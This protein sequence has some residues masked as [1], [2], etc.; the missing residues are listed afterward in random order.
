MHSPLRSL[1]IFTLVLLNY[2][3]FTEVSLSALEVVYGIGAQLVPLLIFLSLS[4]LAQCKP[5]FFAQRHFSFAMVVVSF[6]STGILAI[7]LQT[8]QIIPLIIGTVLLGFAI[9]WIEV[10]ATLTLVGLE[11]TTCSFVLAIAY[12]ASHLFM[13]L[14]PHI[15]RIWGLGLIDLTTL[16]LF[17]TS[18]S[19]QKILT[20]Y[21][22]ISPPYKLSST[23][24]F[25]FLSF[26]SGFFWL[27]LLVAVVFGYLCQGP[28]PMKA[29]VFGF[30][31]FAPLL[32]LVLCF[33]A[34]RGTLSSDTLFKVAACFVI[35]ALILGLSFEGGGQSLAKRLSFSGSELYDLIFYWYVLSIVGAKNQMAVL[36]ALCWG[37]S[38][39]IL[40]FILGSHARIWSSTL[41]ILNQD[42]GKL[43]LCL[44]ALVFLIYI[45]MMSDSLR[46]D[47]TAHCVS[48]PYTGTG[49]SSN[50]GKE[51][52][53]NCRRILTAQYRLTDREYEVYD[54]LRQGRD[55]D[56][57]KERLFISRNTVRS[58]TR[59]I[60][61]KLGIHSQQD[62]ISF[63]EEL[64]SAPEGNRPRCTNNSETDR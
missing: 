24:P 32:A 7:G 25:S 12:I 41:A 3:L 29:D 64:I 22:T 13:P 61:L 44:I 1:L 28:I 46:F 57:I 34:H 54:L 50:E 39:L 58:H 56:R 17:L 55:C 26:N 10:R 40:G 60:Y 21:E 48:S 2:W 4:V 63:D 62:L 14:A 27:L 43:P 23:N 19:S 38:M 52:R 51:G 47:E 15:D 59:S 35:A 16:T 18:H 31:T 6:L 11:T 36:P 8:S 30:L 20:A 49:T 5:A 37:R 53:D 42:L 45:T 9:F 33:L